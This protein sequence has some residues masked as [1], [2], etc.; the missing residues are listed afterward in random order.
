M[1]RLTGEVILDQFSAASSD[2]G[3]GSQVLAVKFTAVH[4]EAALSTVRVH[5]ERDLPLLQA[6]ASNDPLAPA[7]NEHQENNCLRSQERH[8]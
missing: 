7:A 2:P 3:A 4:G 1:A 8:D 5:A 6:Q